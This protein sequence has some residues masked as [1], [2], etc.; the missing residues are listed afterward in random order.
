M[1]NVFAVALAAGLALLP[2][3]AHAQSPAVEEAMSHA[4]K[5]NGL[6]YRFMRCLAWEET[7]WLPWKSNGN[8]YHGLYQFDW[9]TWN[10]NA[11]QYG[12]A[13]ASPYNAWAAAHVAA[14]MISSQPLARTQSTWPP[15]R[16][17]GSP[18]R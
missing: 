14:G 16:R 6:A 11:P 3:R 1:R 15:A 10:G 13:G 2:V 4:A 12:F 17:C 5:T 9:P 7:R 18:W 8:L